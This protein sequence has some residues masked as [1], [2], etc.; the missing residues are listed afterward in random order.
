MATRGVLVKLVERD[1]LIASYYLAP[2]IFDSSPRPTS[3]H[4]LS[5]HPTSSH[6]FLLMFSLL[7]IITSHACILMSNIPGP[8]MT[9]G[10]CSH[11]AANSVVLVVSPMVI[12]CKGPCDHPPIFPPLFLARRF[13][14]VP[15]SWILLK[16][17]RRHHSLLH[18]ACSIVS[19]CELLP[20]TRSGTYFATDACAA[21]CYLPLACA[22]SYNLILTFRLS[23]YLLLLP[24]KV[25]SR[26]VISWFLV[27][28]L[29]PNYH[30][31]V[32]V[33]QQVHGRSF[34]EWTLNSNINCHGRSRGSK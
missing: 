11:L 12:P 21:S 10:N 7:V 19:C 9:V 24:T 6:Y 28:L 14:P 29:T 23:Y 8:Q 18:I 15:H 22:T 5:L 27:Q 2:F 30:Q 3:S 25:V 32:G 1:L 4:F 20:A 17:A 13:P 31:L 33:F 26:P 34:T 16:L